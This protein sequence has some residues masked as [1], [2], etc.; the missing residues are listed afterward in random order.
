MGDILPKQDVFHAVGRSNN[1]ANALITRMI[2]EGFT[3]QKSGKGGF[4]RDDRAI[5]LTTGIMRPRISALPSMAQQAS[6]AQ[7]EGF[8]ATLRHYPLF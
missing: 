8:P 4:Y 3:G 1:P 5:D 2:S 6:I 7:K